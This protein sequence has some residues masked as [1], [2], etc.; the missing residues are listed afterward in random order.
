MR[1]LV[2]TRRGVCGTAWLLATVL[3]GLAGWAAAEDRAR[4]AASISLSEGVRTRCLDILRA[5]IRSSEFWPAMH[6]AEGLTLAGYGGEVRSCLNPKLATEQ[7]DRHRCGLARELV[8]AGDLSKVAVMLDVLAKQDSDGHVHAC[9]SLFKCFR[10]GD[11]HRLRAAMRRTDSP[12]LQ[13]MAAAALGRCG[14]PEAKMLLREK[15]KSDDHEVQRIAAW[16][17]GA[18][19]DAS[20]IPQIRSNVKRTSDPLARAFG[21]HAL[22]QLGD[23]EGRA[24]LLRNLRSGDPAVRTY[25][26]NSAGEARVASA[27]AALIALLDDPQPD[28]Q[29]RAAQSLL[30]LLQAEESA[31]EANF[32]R[33][34]Y[35]A[36]KQNPRYTEGSII[37]L[38]DGTLLFAVSEFAGSGADHATAQI[39][40]RSSTDGGRTWGEPR[41]LQENVGKQNVMSVTL[42]RLAPAANGPAPI[43]MFYLVK[44]GPD[45]LE[46]HVRISTDETRTFGE[47]IRVTDRPGYHVM[48]N[49]RVT[50]LSTGRLLAPIAATE[51]LRKNHFVSSCCLSDDG[52][53]TWRYGRGQVALPKRG[54]MEPE[55]VE[56]LD[57]RVLMVVRNQLGTISAAWS[58]DGGDTWSQPG[59]LPDIQAPEAPAT[60][61]RIPA[62]GDLLLVWNNTYTPGIGHGGRRT[63]LAAAISR[64]DG[65][66]WQNFRNL[67]SRQDEQYAYTSLTFVRDRAVLSYYVADGKTGFH[68]SRFRSVPVAWFYSASQTSADGGLVVR[69][70]PS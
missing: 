43:G 41:L 69:T 59:E 44:N 10:S 68:S 67:E 4:P 39:I 18:I 42:R 8:R 15:L 33:D 29:I 7:D 50:V 61:R 2:D 54:A 11:G 66:T 48:N 17:L 64:D 70:E 22:A 53:R 23:P 6:A 31:P 52:G 27:A 20:D 63:P 14:S 16:V 49:D 47:P 24:A 32:S 46:V 30:A 40:A 5:G 56:L 3:A 21:E 34:V 58:E 57:G 51:S 28:A 38:N 62:T 25:A 9:E 55:V 12:T 37:E 1:V 60:L 35:P 36:T 13:M 26:A 19:G 45:S 65:R